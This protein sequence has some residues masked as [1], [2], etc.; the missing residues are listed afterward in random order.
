[1]KG[2]RNLEP[3]HLPKTGSRSGFDYSFFFLPNQMCRKIRESDAYLT[4]LT[5]SLASLC[6]ETKLNYGRCIREVELQSWSESKDLLLRMK[7]ELKIR[8]RLDDLKKPIFEFVT[9]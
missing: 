4:I 2:P 3:A 8:S 6:Q 7:G 1:M 5:H 9:I